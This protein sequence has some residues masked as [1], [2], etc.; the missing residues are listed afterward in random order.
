MR[1]LP[2]FALLALCVVEGCSGGGGDDDD[3]AL[4]PGGT[5]TSGTYEASKWHKVVD[6]CHAMSSRNGQDLTVTVTGTALQIGLATGMI[7]DSNLAIVETGEID[8]NTD[9]YGFGAVDCVVATELHLD[10][11]CMGNDVADLVEQQDVSVISGAECDQAE[12]GV[13]DLAGATIHL[14]CHSESEFRITKTGP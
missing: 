9:P 4:T 10:G 7:L 11:V 2:L 13:S 14:P 8:F 6:D 5:L 3:D 1:G 12:E